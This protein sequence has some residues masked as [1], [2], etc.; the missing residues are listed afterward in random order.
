MERHQDIRGLDVA[1]DHS[2]MV[3]VLDRVADVDE[4]PKAILGLHLVAVAELGDGDSLDEFHH[5]E[6]P[7]GLSRAGVEHLG[8]I[9]VVHQGQRLTFRLEPRDHLSGVHARLDDFQGDDPAHGLHL[10]GHVNNAEAPLADL[11]QELVGTDKPARFFKHRRP[12]DLR[13]QV[14]STLNAPHRAVGVEQHL[15]PDLQLGVT[16]AKLFQGRLPLVF[17]PFEHGEEHGSSL[18]FDLRHESCSH[19]RRRFPHKRV[20]VP[21]VDF[22]TGSEIF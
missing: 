2:F 1:V 6:R 8:D 22:L 10:L 21:R 17:R 20:R 7:A 12:D 11:L 16:G 19:G 3:G 14:V 18:V 4:E 15:R 5:E 9:G 13:G